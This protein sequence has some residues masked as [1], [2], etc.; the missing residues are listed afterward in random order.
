MHLA[1]DTQR[2]DNPASNSWSLT[3]ARVLS[4][5][6]QKGGVGKTTSAVNIAAAFALSGHNV[7]IIGTDPQCGVSRS[8]GFAPEQLHGGLREV[9]LSGLPLSQVAHETAL[10]NLSMVVPDAWSLPEEQQYKSLMNDQADTFVR[11]VEEARDEYDTIVIDC[12]PGYGP[13]TTAAMTAS[14][15][16]LVP[17]QAEE[18]SRDSLQRLLRFTEEH[19]A[20]LSIPLELEGLFMTM[21]DHRTKMSRHVAQSLDTEYGTQLFD[22]SV[23]RNTRLAEMALQGRPTVIYDRLSAGSRAYFNLVDEVMVRWYKR[24]EEMRQTIAPRVEHQ[25]AEISNFGDAALKSWAAASGGTD[26]ALPPTP[27]DADPERQESTVLQGLSRFMQALAGNEAAQPEASGSG[28]GA[29]M[30][31]DN[32]AEDSPD[33]MSLDDLLE[34]EE[35]SAGNSHNDAAWGLGE[36]DYDTIN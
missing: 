35:N 30:P 4:L 31:W 27:M 6:S 10:D 5:V 2:E 25:S 11:A 36:D 3:R 16:F 14:D 9:I 22:C 33:M 18:L 26:Q 34:E 17:V 24:P 8:L 13:E 29:E 23:P 15:S 7:L 19:S 32:P 21:T 1:Q 28:Q 20:H 12:P